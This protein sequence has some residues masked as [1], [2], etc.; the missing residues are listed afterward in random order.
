MCVRT[1]SRGAGDQLAIGFFELVSCFVGQVR[2]DGKHHA[3]GAGRAEPLKFAD[4][5]TNLLYVRELG[6]RDIG[7]RRQNG[8]SI[9]LGNI[10]NI[11]GRQQMGRTRHMLQDHG[12]FPR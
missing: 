1:R 9:G 3:I 7:I 5:E 11:I 6:D 4:I 10:E 2:S 12:G 8:Q